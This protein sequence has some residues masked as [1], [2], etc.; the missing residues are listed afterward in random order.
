[1]TGE[2]EI[3]LGYLDRAAALFDPDTHGRWPLRLGPSPGVVAFAVGGLLRWVLGYPEAADR[4]AAGA[5][6]IAAR[7]G[8]PYSL[9]YAT[10]HVGLLDLWNRRL[11]SARAR[12]RAVGAIAEERDYPV[13]RATSLVLEGV[14]ASLLGDADAGIALV[15]RGISLYENAGAPPIFWPQLLSLRARACAAVGRPDEGLRAVDEAIA[16]AGPQDAFDRAPLLVQ[17]GDLSVALGDLA[18]AESRLEEARAVAELLGARMIELQALTRLARLSGAATGGARR[19]E[20][21]EALDAVLDSM[22]EGAGSPDVAEARAAL[23][24][25]RSALA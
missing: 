24:D 10:F 8:S 5:L 7:L 6:E 4:Y 2:H 1:M 21:A 14:T 17:A 18:G 13:W 12:A 20:R 3:G 15:D 25:L 19:T 9:A 22:T 23:A 11:E 16:L